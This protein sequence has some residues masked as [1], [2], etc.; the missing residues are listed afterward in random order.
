MYFHLHLPVEEKVTTGNRKV[1]RL[2][3]FQRNFCWMVVVVVVVVVDFQG[4]KIPAHLLRE[5]VLNL[6]S[7]TA[8]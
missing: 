6:Y 2:L 4:N 7:T 1:W 3:K 8:V 5:V